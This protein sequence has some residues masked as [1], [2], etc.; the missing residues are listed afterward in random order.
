LN[1]PV[2]SARVAIVCPDGESS[3]KGAPS[4]R[5]GAAA[6]ERALGRIATLVAEGASPDEVF[7]AVAVEV[8]RVLAVAAVTGGRFEPDRTITVRRTEHSW[9]RDREPVAT[10]RSENLGDDSGHRPRGAR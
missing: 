7:A 4:G 2:E 1:T 3:I 6:Y 9:A 8:S 10:G 5:G